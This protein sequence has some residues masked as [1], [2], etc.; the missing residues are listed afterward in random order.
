MMH[1]NAS[2][3]RPQQPSYPSDSAPGGFATKARGGGFG[4]PRGGGYGKP[5]DGGGQDFGPPKPRVNFDR[6]PSAPH[7]RKGHFNINVEVKDELYHSFNEKLKADGK[8]SK[9]VL[10]QLISFYIMGKINV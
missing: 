1:H 2:T 6:P 9:E 8:S 4:K 5:R 7:A 10:S 3:Q